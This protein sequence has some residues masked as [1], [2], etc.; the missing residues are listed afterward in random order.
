MKFF[1]ARVRRKGGT[2][3]S[4]WCL[5]LLFT[6]G[7]CL[8]TAK[9]SALRRRSAAVSSLSVTMR[10]WVPK[11]VSLEEWRK[12]RKQ[13]DE[14]KVFAAPCDVHIQA[15]VGAVGNLR[16]GDTVSVDFF[17]NTNNIGS[18]TCVW[19]EEVNPSKQ[20]HGR[21]AVPLFIIPAQF[22]PAAM[23]WHNPPPGKYA[24][25]AKASCGK[26]VSAVSTPFNITI[27]AAPQP[28]N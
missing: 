17:A 12:H 3:Y 24:L 15:S 28:D 11:T 27:T 1:N 14:D 5:V 25:T 8:V 10:A 18:G 7:V 23:V 9:T 2:M 6:A 21:G 22:S 19:H 16:A 13:L 4:R 26:T 20:W